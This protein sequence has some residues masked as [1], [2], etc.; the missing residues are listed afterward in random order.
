[1]KSEAD[2]DIDEYMEDVRAANFEVLQQRLAEVKSE[3]S[4][5]LGLLQTDLQHMG[6]SPASSPDTLHA[7]INT[8][9]SPSVEKPIEAVSCIVSGVSAAVLAREMLLEPDRVQ[10]YNRHLKTTIYCLLKLAE[11]SIDERV[12][13][14]IIGLA[15]SAKKSLELGA[16]G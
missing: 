9:N 2:L 3:L 14:S 4:A 11:S 1:M 10:A 16:R 5:S 8:L 7:A 12:R 15:V 6:I 13:G